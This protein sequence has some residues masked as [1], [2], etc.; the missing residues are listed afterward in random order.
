[1]DLS[2]AA[3]CYS[4]G[5]KYEVAIPVHCI[6]SGIIN[7]ISLRDSVPKYGF[8]TLFYIIIIKIICVILLNYHNYMAKIQQYKPANSTVNTSII[9]K[10]V[11]RIK[12]NW[13][14]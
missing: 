9:Q 7:N 10:T 1:M 11:G 14:K 6:C 12:G 5:L 2:A 3:I 8:P 13:C 4:T